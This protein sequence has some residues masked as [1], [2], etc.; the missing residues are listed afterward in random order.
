MAACTENTTRRDLDLAGR[1]GALNTESPGGLG[2]CAPDF[3][4]IMIFLSSIDLL[5][6]VVSFSGAIVCAGTVFVLS[7]YDC[8]P[9]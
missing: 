2:G 8:E 4:N 1:Q 3:Y 7:S 6:P 5:T 9:F